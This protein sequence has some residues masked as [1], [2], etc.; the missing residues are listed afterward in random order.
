MAT[1]TI[2]NIPDGVYQ[3]LKQQASLHRR[4][5]NQEVIACLEHSTGSVPLDPAVFLARAQEI[6]KMVKGPRLTESRLKHLKTVGR[7]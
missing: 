6:R 1:L 7:L 5:L 4:S 3:H 2:K